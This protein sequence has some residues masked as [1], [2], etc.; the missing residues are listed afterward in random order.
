MKAPSPAGRSPPGAIPAPSSSSSPDPAPS[1]R[2]SMNAAWPA[3]VG[4]TRR[5]SVVIEPSCHPPRSAASGSGIEHQAPAADGAP[6]RARMGFAAP[7]RPC[8]EGPRHR[9]GRMVAG[10][11]TQPQLADPRSAAGVLAPAGPRGGAAPAPAGAPPRA[12][13]GF[14]AP[15]RPCAEGSRHR[16]GR[17]VAGIDTQHQ[18][19]DPRLGAG[20]LEQGGGDG[21]AVPAAAVGLE[22]PVGQRRLTPLDPGAE[23]RQSS[24]AD[25]LA[26]PVAGAAQSAVLP[27]RT[28]GAP[29]L[30]ALEERL[31]PRAVPAPADD[32]PGQ[33]LVLAGQDRLA[34]AGSQGLEVDHA[35][36][37]S[38]RA[39]RT[40]RRIW[41]SPCPPALAVATAAAISS[42]SWGSTRS[43]GTIG[44][45]A[46]AFSAAAEASGAMV[47]PAPRRVTMTCSSSSSL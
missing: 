39:W 46:T 38:P 16:L 40:A 47:V 31:E 18:L 34:M 45:A 42:S 14:A 44:R 32:L 11:D 1:A 4:G 12:R 28:V 15:R 24:A 9:L 2:Q 33:Q 29:V 43:A 7:R 8:A 21:V 19:A 27:Q 36:S 10:I 37:A 41:A 30:H 35:R 3:L 5:I 22:H 23:Q 26:L 6:P 25:Q 17:M 13:M 20:V